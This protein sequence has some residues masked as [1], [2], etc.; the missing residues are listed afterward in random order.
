MRV[1]LGCVLLAGGG[2]WLG[3]S[4]AAGLKGELRCMEELSRGLAL[5]EQELNRGSPELC[6]LARDLGDRTRG[7]S[8]QLFQTFSRGMEE[9]EGSGVARL[10]EQAVMSLPALPEEGAA[11]LRPLGEILGRYESPEQARAVE[12][13]RRELDRLAQSRRGDYQVRGRLWQTVGL[14]GGSFLAIL[15]L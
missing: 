10:W 5:L 7:A 15:L 14:A 1:L 8:R 12:E 6:R 3:F 2:V 4:A 13:V 9:M 11:C